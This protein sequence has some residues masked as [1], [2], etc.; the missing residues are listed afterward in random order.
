MR[1][2]EFCCLFLENFEVVK[3]ANDCYEVN[4]LLPEAYFACSDSCFNFNESSQVFFLMSLAQR[5]TPQCP[6]A[7]IFP[8]SLDLC[9]SDHKLI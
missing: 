6:D 4:N 2:Q 3:Q 1:M 5:F 7:F 8:I 9:S